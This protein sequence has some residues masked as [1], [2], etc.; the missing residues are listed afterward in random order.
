[1]QFGINHESFPAIHFK[2]ENLKL[3]LL[4]FFYI[5]SVNPVAKLQKYSYPPF[6]VI[7]IIA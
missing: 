4:I 7:C 6:M 1:M 5:M 3:F 2:M